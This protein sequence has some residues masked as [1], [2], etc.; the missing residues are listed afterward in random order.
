MVW[1]SAVNHEEL[2]TMSHNWCPRLWG[3]YTKRWSVSVPEPMNRKANDCLTG[4]VFPATDLGTVVMCLSFSSQLRTRAVPRPLPK[5]G[6][7]NQRNHLC[8]WKSKSERCVAS[9]LRTSL[10][11]WWKIPVGSDPD[12]L[13]AVSEA[14]LHLREVLLLIK[15][16][17]DVSA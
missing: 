9:T 4:F 5:G 11:T 14:H 15:E 8:T 10:I 1:W 13:W 6:V 7:W 2:S 3:F 12:S 16:V 17:P